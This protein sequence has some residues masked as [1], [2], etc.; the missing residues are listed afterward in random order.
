MALDHISYNIGT[1]H[2]A[3]LRNGLTLLEDGLDR[4]N[5]LLATMARMI[6]GDGSDAMHFAYMQEKFGFASNAAAKSAWD[7]LNSLLAKLN[8]DSQVTSVNA[9]LLQAFAKFR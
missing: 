7:E 1:Q 2:G 4:L 9:A 5:D 8:T 3:M 6:D